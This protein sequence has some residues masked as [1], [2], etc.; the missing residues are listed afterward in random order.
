MKTSDLNWSANSHS[1]TPDSKSYKKKKKSYIVLQDSQ[2]Y[3][4]ILLISG[5]GIPGIPCNGRE[6]AFF[7]SLRDRR[8]K[9]SSDFDNVVAFCARFFLLI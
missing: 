5:L 2:D 6:R 4:S 8:W 1:F 7:W 9:I 3:W